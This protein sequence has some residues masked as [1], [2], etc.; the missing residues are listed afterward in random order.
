MSQPRQPS[1]FPLTKNVQ[2][3]SLS[4]SFA[5]PPNAGGGTIP[6]VPQIPDVP[7]KPSL[8]RLSDPVVS[9]QEVRRELV[10]SEQKKTACTTTVPERGQKQ[11]DEE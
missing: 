6:E 9:W 4:A 7:D 2:H 1:T 3:I 11:K 8:S 10:L 5:L